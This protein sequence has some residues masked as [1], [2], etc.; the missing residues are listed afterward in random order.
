MRG[1]GVRWTI[2]QSDGRA[3]L[4]L[5]EAAVRT[6]SSELARISSP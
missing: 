3:F 2:V 6:A 5:G 4:A 1:V